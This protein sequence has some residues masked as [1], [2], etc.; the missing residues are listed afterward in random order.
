[1]GVGVDVDV[2]AA[3]EERLD[4]A[5]YR[6]RVG[7]W[8]EVRRFR[9]RGG[10]NYTM[11]ANRRALV[12]Y[13]LEEAEAPLL[14]LMD[15]TRTVGEIV[16]EHLETS[17]ELD[18]AGVSEVVRSL[19]EGGFLT[20]AYIDVDAALERALVPHDTRFRLVRALRTGSV[21]WSGAEGLTRWLHRRGLRH[22]FGPVGIGLAFALVAVGVVALL[23]AVAA[24]TYDL[25]TR[26]VLVGFVFFF[27]LNLVLVFI[28]ELGHATYLVHH[29]RRIR[30]SGLRLAMG[31]PV[32]F[33]DSSDVL[34]LGRRERMAQSFAGPYFELVATAIASIALWVWPTG[35]AGDLLFPFVILSYFGLLLNLLPLLELD[36]YWI[37]ADAIR[38]RDLRPRAR[39]FLRHDLWAKLSRRARFSTAEIGLGLYGT[40]GVLFTALGLAAA[41]ALWFSTF[42]GLVTEMWDAGPLGI[43]LLVLLLGFLAGPLLRGLLELT[44]SALRA[45]ER[46]ARR[47]RF[48]HELWWRVEAAALLGALPI[49]DGLP[50]E[51]REELVSAVRLRRIAA[52]TAVVRQGDRADAMF[53]V[54]S[55]RL[56]ALETDL[57]TQDE[58]VIDTIGP[59]RSFGE[60]GVATGAPRRATIRA[61]APSEL[62]V[63]DRGTFD[64]L[65]A[66]R[67]RL[68]SFAPTIHALTELRDLPAFAQLDVNG[69]AEL[70]R[71][72]R[73]ETVPAGATVIREG[74]IGDAFYAVGSGQLDVLQDGVQVNTLGPRDHFGEIALL[75][76][77]P[78]TATVQ[79]TTAA[80]VFRLDRAAFDALLAHAFV[81]DDQLMPTSAFRQA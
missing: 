3:V 34:M 50:P 12:Y 51:V 33:V 58:R 63:I 6:P 76:D 21:S 29:D 67:V 42:G 59:G 56:E 81:P 48:R 1:M 43:L 15:G 2:W 22:L 36:G 11:A 20:D 49:F 7:D 80:R 28:H 41:A 40:V 46:L 64:R 78:R 75:A 70:A 65:L 19:H 73:W 13:R 62:F 54:R 39:A 26:S 79:A 44:R 53:V 72:G 74:D 31:T 38:V 55:G 5:A 18:L 30:G 57:E 61:V 8:V 66:D 32:F 4:P 77:V 10:R 35:M 71:R 47:V 60:L 25:T 37:L 23:G 14:D 45:L 9:E 17:G 27:C 68:P 24:H 69:L 16:V 52:E